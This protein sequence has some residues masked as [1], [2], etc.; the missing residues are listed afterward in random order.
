MTVDAESLPA[1]YENILSFPWFRCY[2][3][4]IDDITTAADRAFGLPLPVRP[5]SATNPNRPVNHT[6]GTDVLEVVHLN[7]TLDDLPD[8]VTFSVTQYGN[9][10]S[11]PD[12]WYMR[13]VVDLLS[14]PI[15]IIGTRLNEPSLWQH[16]ENRGARGSRQ[17]GELRPRS[18]L[19]TPQLARARRALLAELNISWI[20]MTGEQF[21]EQ[22]LC[23]LHDARDRGLKF[24]RT[25]S[26]GMDRSRD[27]PDVADLAIN[28]T[29]ET[30]FLLGDEP[31]WA[32]LQSGRAIHRDSDDQLWSGIT[33]AL[34]GDSSSLIVVTGTAGSGKSTTLMGAC[35]KLMAQ[36][37]RVGWV[38]RDGSLSPYDILRSAKTENGPRALAID[39]CRH[40]RFLS[41]VHGQRLVGGQKWPL[42]TGSPT[43]V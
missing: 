5:I 37:E 13:F 29:A 20:P 3:L 26:G 10:L 24:L 14:H 15:V 39:D 2:T 30:K 31:I 6:D 1:W 27:A 35:L 41:G 19:V 8:H 25:H 33:T 4:N 22:V 16:L 18:Y 23:Q 42:G 12:P 34:R 7:G 36:G 38:D 11:K 28:P 43:V 32:D 40:L 9:R 17:L 21:A